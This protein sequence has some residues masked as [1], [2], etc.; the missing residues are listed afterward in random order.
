MGLRSWSLLRCCLTP[1]P[2]IIIIL[3]LISFEIIM[4]LFSMN[5]TTLTTAEF[6]QLFSSSFPILVFGNPITHC[7]LVATEDDDICTV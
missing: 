7:H 5:F 1:P 2:N 3:I 6:E 4:I